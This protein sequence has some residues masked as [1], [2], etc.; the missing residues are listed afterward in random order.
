MT[1]V[2]KNTK[3][4]TKKNRWKEKGGRGGIRETS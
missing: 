1:F 3:K 4:Q 2:K